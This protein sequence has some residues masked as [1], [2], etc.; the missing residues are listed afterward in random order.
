MRTG[1]TADVA[2]RWRAAAPPRWPRAVAAAGWVAAL[3]VSVLADT[4]SC[5][6]TDPTVCGPDLGFAVAAVFLV[7]AIA[8]LF[9]RPVLAATCAVVFAAADLRFD[10]L[11]AANAAW[12]VSAF[13]TVGA[14]ALRHRAIRTQRRII[15]EVADDVRLE[16]VP[17]GPRPRDTIE[18]VFAIGV[19]LALAGVVGCLGLW[20]TAEDEEAT[21]RARSV[22]VEGTV[23]AVAAEDDGDTRL[24]LR[25][26]RLVGGIGET[27]RVDSLDDHAVGDVLPVR[28]DPTDADW[29]H[30]VAEPPDQTWWATLAGLALLGGLVCGARAAAGPV[31]RRLLS[32]SRQRGPRVRWFVDDADLLHLVTLDEDQVVAE[33]PVEETLRLATALD[34]TP[35]PP[36]DG[37]LV[38]DV[39]EGGW[40]AVLTDGARLLPVGPL[41][42]GELLLFDADD[43]ERDPEDVA[44]WTDEVPAGTVPH[45]L[46]YTPPTPWWSRGLGLLALAGSVAWVWVA[47]AGSTNPWLAVLHVAA[48]VG[49][50]YAG[51][52][53]LVHRATVTDASVELVGPLVTRRVPLSAVQSVRISAEGSVVLLVGGDDVVELRPPDPDPVELEHLESEIESES[54][55]EGEDDDRDWEGLERLRADSA[56]RLGAAVEQARDAVLRSQLSD[57]PTGATSRQQVPGRRG[58]GAVSGP[59]RW[60][61]AVVL[62]WLVLG[63]VLLAR[64][65]G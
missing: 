9:Y 47:G 64:W 10:P 38:G 50:A 13:L 19:V 58:A 26:D 41:L 54:E 40:V 32:G 28:V 42:S 15:D 56:A 30:L 16:P 53:R 57:L 18:R 25:L 21:H 52:E 36:R 60:L 37:R 51:W 7:G 8:L 12:L 31:R 14:A 23:T 63:V 29:T 22:V 20:R 6:T 55:I 17:P 43:L 11:V 27:V 62:T 24:T 35:G 48:P 45:P 49:L 4:R 46:P 61:P 1:L 33:F 65:S 44:A 2:A 59:S 3:V 5:S 34:R 39:R